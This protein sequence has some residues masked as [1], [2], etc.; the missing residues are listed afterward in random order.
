MAASNIRLTLQRRAM[1]YERHILLGEN[2]EVSFIALL[3]PRVVFS[4]TLV[5][6]RQ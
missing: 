2:I 3:C 4:P 5:Q 6:E 1:H